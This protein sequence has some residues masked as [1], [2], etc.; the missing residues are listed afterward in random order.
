MKIVIQQG[1]VIDPSQHLDQITNIYLSRG[2]ILHIGEQ[3]PDGFVADQIVDARDKWVFP[4]LIDMQARLGEP[5]QHHTGTIASETKAAV[6]GGITGLCCPPDTDPVTDSQAVAELIQRRA[7][8]AATAFVMPIGALTQ[9]LNGERLSEMHALKQGGCIALSQANRPIQNPLIL[10]NALDYAASHNLLV[11]LR[12]EN[13]HLKNNGVAHS[14]AVSSR[15]G[16]PGIPP[17]AETIALARDLI[18]VE[19]SGVRAHFSQLSCA[20]SVEMIQAAKQRGLPVSCDVAIHQLHLTEMDVMTFSSLTHVSPPL[21][22]HADREA[23]RM[24]VKTGV[25]DVIV[26]DHT[27]LGRDEKQLPFGE[28]TPGISGLETLLALTLRL[29]DEGVLTLPQAI[30]CLSEHPANILGLNVGR[31]AKGHSA[32]LVIYNPQ[33]IWQVRADQLHSAGKNSPFIGWEFNGRVETTLFQGRPVY[34][35]D[36]V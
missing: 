8:Q 14:G 15:L 23:L 24:G 6:A 36:D 34:R 27:P 28:S 1:R 33:S 2:H 7:R 31:L 11:I 12:T 16:L 25:I 4:G 30:Q 9:G 5:G 29:V 13:Q 10:K 21:R 3:A 17:S 26:S 32:D 22:S 19:E 35:A 20:R 18:L